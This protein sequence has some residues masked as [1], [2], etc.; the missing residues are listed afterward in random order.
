M[1]R[2]EVALDRRSALVELAGERVSATLLASA[3]VEHNGRACAMVMAR[4]QPRS[5][6]VIWVTLR[7][8]ASDAEDE[9]VRAKAAAAIADL[10]AQ[11][12]ILAE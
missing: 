7:N 11:T 2:R 8:Q 4:R 9:V 3:V 12:G 6:E 10:Q 5:G 1:W